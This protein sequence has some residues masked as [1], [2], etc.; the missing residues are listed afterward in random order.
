MHALLLLVLSPVLADIPAE[1]RWIAS[2]WV[3]AGLAP[4]GSLVN[5]DIGLG[6]LVDPDGASGPAPIGGDALVVGRSFEAWSA[7]WEGGQCANSAPDGGSDVLFDWGEPAATSAMAY[8]HASAERPE[9]TLGLWVEAPWDE[10]W[11]RL[12]I[13]LTAL[14]DLVGL[15]VARVVDP[16]MDFW[17]SGSYATTNRVGDGWVSATGSADGRV[18]VLAAP[19][20]SGGI[21]SWCTLASELEAAGGSESE[22]DEQVGVW[23]QVGDLAAGESTTVSFAYAFGTDEDSAVALAS[24][25]AATED[26]D[27]DGWTEAEGDCDDREPLISP[28][29]GEAWDGLDN[30][31]D[32]EVDEDTA[33]SDDDGDGYS[34]AEGDCD[35][36]DPAVHPSAEPSPGVRDADCDGHADTG[37]WPPE[38]PEEQEVSWSET[39]LEGGCHAAGSAPAL[40]WVGGLLLLGL[41]RRRGG[42]E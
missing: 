16:D 37:A 13:E 25:A 23:F 17:M 26:H 35:D 36:G 41:R 39:E 19:G 11:L 30:D 29:E 40:A 3:A 32:G 28:G 12:S 20:G 10:P 27:G 4:D 15:R 21:C 22:G 2:D 9:L 38:L 14:E 6:L 1:D 42:E 8:L 7:E 31:C 18:M 24:A 5:E 34:E 33:G